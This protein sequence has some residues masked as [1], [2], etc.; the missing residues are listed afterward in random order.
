[1]TGWIDIINFAM[2]FAGLS[3]ALLGLMLACTIQS[4]DKWTRNYFMIFF[5][6]I[7]VYVAFSLISQITFALP[8]EQLAPVS[9]L[10]LFLESLCSS[11][12]LLLLTAHLLHLL[13]SDW[14]KSTLFRIAFAIWL[15]YA[16]LLI[17]TQFTRVIYFISPDNV[18]WRG[19]FYP[20]LLLPPLAIMLLNLMLLITGWRHLVP[21]YRISFAVYILI[22]AISMVI[23]IYFYGLLMI[24]LG[25]VLA[26]LVMFASILNYQAEQQIRQSEQIM[27]QKIDIQ[28]LQ[29]R[30]HFIYNTLM[31]I[32]YL[33]DEDTKKAKSV[34]HDF[35]TYLQKNFRA[36]SLNS[37]ISF[38]EEL[39]HASAYLAVEKARYEDSLFIS[40]DTPCTLFRLP[41]LTLQPIVEN[42]VKH[43]LEPG[44]SEL[45]I[46]VRTHTDDKG[47]YIT[48]ENDGSDFEPANDNEPH[49]GIENTRQRLEMMCGG[50]LTVTPRDGGGAVVTI[51]V[52]RSCKKPL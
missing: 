13:G 27:Q 3:L 26:A 45:H 22:P 52:P 6:I 9:R 5:S 49:I 43:G 48:V 37:L 46:Y 44:I 16:A 32:Y 40:F 15:I 39:E 12:L 4:R 2:S 51:F 41:P 50:T 23:Q 11:V 8:Y 24:V 19:P 7:T 14:R 30:P 10:A 42:A 31:S 38:D 18:Y 28:L 34:I 20:A 25:T 36:L 17:F 29:M 21:T 1:M 33:C 47:S 35:T